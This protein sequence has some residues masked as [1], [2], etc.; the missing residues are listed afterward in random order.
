MYNN[1]Y[2]F[3]INYRRMSSNEVECRD[4]GTAK[5]LGVFTKVDL[6][7]STDV[8]TDMEDEI[9]NM[10]E[11]RLYHFGTVKESIVSVAP[12]IEPYVEGKINSIDHDTVLFINHRCECRD[13]GT[14]KGFGVFTNV[15]LDSGTDVWTEKEDE[16][17][18]SSDEIANMTEEQKGRLYHFGT[19]KEGIVSVAPCIKPYVEGVTDSIDH[20]KLDFVLFI[21]HSCEPNLVWKD[22]NTLMT[23][24]CVKA[25]EE[26]TQ[27]Y[28]T[29]DFEVHAFECHCGEVNCRKYIK[30]QEWR[31][32]EMQRKYGSFFQSHIIRAMERDN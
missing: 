15:E 29:E 19:V 23:N 7:H 28:G 24:R 20:E 22:G 9:A 10:T 25:G 8:W 17:E 11:E 13:T 18:F 14:P 31:K 26:L 1:N 32:P 27:D 30:G 16:I 6:D 21:N 12:C 5:G 4:T 2:Y 3:C